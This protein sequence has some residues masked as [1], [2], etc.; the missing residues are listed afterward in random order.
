[1]T[2]ARALIAMG[3]SGSGKTTVGELLAEHYDWPFFDA[4]DFHPKENVEK[5][6]QGTPLNDDDRK[7]WL[8]RLNK[9]LGEHLERGDSVVLACSAL[10][11]S[12][13]DLL[14]VG[15]DGVQFIYLQGS[16][17]LILARMQARA[18]HYMKADMLKSQFK[19]LEE[20]VDALTVSIDADPEAIAAQI[21]EYLEK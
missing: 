15:N 14:S 16:Y 17:D 8:E 3:V 6:A 1:M 19:T 4:D 7:P 18:G 21:V 10:K 5:M 11:Q 2:E 20:P 13:R 9:L 12:Y